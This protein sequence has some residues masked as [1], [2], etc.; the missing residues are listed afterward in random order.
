MPCLPGIPPNLKLEI[1]ATQLI[2]ISFLVKAELLFK[3]IPT[4]IVIEEEVVN[5]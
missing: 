4:M 5:T 1:M 3:V 2:Q